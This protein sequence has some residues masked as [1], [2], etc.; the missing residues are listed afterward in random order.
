MPLTGQYELVLSG[1]GQGNSAGCKVTM[2]K[3]FKQGE[4][5]KFFIGSFLGGV[6]VFD[7]AYQ[8]IAVAGSAGQSQEEKI[9]CSG[10]V[11]F[12]YTRRFL[13]RILGSDHSKHGRNLFYIRATVTLKASFDKEKDPEYDKLFT[14]S[15]PEE[16]KGFD[17]SDVI[18]G[19][20][21]K[22]WGGSGFQAGDKHDS[23]LSFQ[24]G[25]SMS[26]SSNAKFER[27]VGDPF[28]KVT[29]LSN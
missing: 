23:A 4:T 26:T 20:D 3:S 9:R 13:G 12:L 18:R 1:W 11:A 21:D 6:F 5:I 16:W 2:I 7:K 15:P 10:S 29:F 19:R 27:V 8:L 17:F 28:L 22:P 14:I 25:S 24:G